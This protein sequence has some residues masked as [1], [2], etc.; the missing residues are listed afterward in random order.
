MK[1]K[2]NSYDETKKLLKTIRNFSF[3]NKSSVLKEQIEQQDNNNLNINGVDVKILFDDSSDKELS[4]EQKENISR[5]IDSF[6]AQVTQLV[7][8]EPG[9]TINNSQVRLDGLLTEYNLKFTFISG[10]ESGVYINGEMIQIEK[11]IIDLINKLYNYNILFKETFDNI[12]NFR[13]TN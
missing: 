7:R 3:N 12:L 5:L 1:D 8:F 10:E 13:F 6:K 2:K 4:N 11:E 9:I